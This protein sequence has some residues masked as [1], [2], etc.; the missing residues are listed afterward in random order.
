[1]HLM[2]LN[3]VIL[4]FRYF[5]SKILLNFYQIQ[6]INYFYYK[7]KQYLRFSFFFGSQYLGSILLP[8]YST[9][10]LYIS[11]LVR[12]LLNEYSFDHITQEHSSKL[13][14]NF[15]HFQYEIFKYT[16]FFDLHQLD[17]S[18]FF[19][20]FSLH[21]LFIFSNSFINIFNI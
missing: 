16:S 4:D 13:Q 1:M 19:I 20:R 9:M 21:K 2:V 14:I 7:T 6:V 10:K 5:I 18:Q 17:Q 3:M 12:I 11:N 15:N 8:S